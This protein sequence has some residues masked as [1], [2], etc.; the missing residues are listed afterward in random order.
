M[1][2]IIVTFA[3]TEAV[4]LHESFEV[5]CQVSTQ[6]RHFLH[7]RRC[8]RDALLDPREVPPYFQK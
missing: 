1:L 3:M 4:A 2:G 8:S 5:E 7:K 6:L